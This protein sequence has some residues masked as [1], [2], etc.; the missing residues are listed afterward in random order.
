MVCQSRQTQVNNKIPKLPT[1]NVNLGISPQKTTTMLI[2]TGAQISLITDKMIKNTSKINTNNKITISS[3]HGTE[4]TLGK[5]FT[6]I[7]KNNVEIPIELHV[8]KNS[9]LKED[10]ILG[11]DVIGEKAIINGP[12]KTITIKSKT[13]PIQFEI[14]RVLKTNTDTN[15]EINNFHKIEYIKENEQESVHYQEN[16]DRVR[17]LTHQINDTKIKISKSKQ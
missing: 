8:T 14:N 15:E 16:L 1:I 10:G 5:I 6:T 9:S 2:D 4:E 12:E 17:Q 3:I 7:N 13:K 11:Y